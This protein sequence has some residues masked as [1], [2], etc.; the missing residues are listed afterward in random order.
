MAT[1]LLVRTGGTAAALGLCAVLLAV[2]PKPV[3][4]PPVG[5][6]QDVIFFTADGPVRLRLTLTRNGQPLDAGW[7][8]A[9]DRLFTFLDRNGNATLEADERTLFRRNREPA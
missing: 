7:G 4:A 8:A 3:A 2:P 9:L 5:T 1:I 6:V